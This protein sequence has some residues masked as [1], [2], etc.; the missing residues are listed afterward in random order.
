[1]FNKHVFGIFVMACL[2]NVA[3]VADDVLVVVTR[4]SEVSAH[5]PGGSDFGSSGKAG[6]GESLELM[7][8]Y[9]FSDSH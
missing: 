1:M 6:G 8:I 5:L 2:G 3:A 4:C 9:H 7:Y